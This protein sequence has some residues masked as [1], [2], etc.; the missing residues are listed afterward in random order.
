[1]AARRVG[2]VYNAFVPSP[3]DTGEQAS[4][5]AVQ[6][7]AE[8]LRDALQ[9]HGVLA[10]MIPLRRSVPGF[11][12]RLREERSDIIV[13][14]C[15]GYLGRPQWESNVAGVLELLQIPFTGSAAKALALCQDKFTTKAILEYAGLPTAPALLLRSADEPVDLE[16]PLIVKPNHEDASIGIHPDSVVHDAESLTRKVRRVLDDYSQPALVE[17]YL[18]GREFS[19]A[20][21]EDPVPRALPVSEIEFTSM[22]ADAPRICGYTAKWFENH[23][24]YQQTPPRCPAEVGDDLR[25][26]LQNIAVGAF[27]ALGCRDYARID[28]RTDIAGDVHILE[29]NPNP[30]VSRDAGFARALSAAGIAYPAFWLTT[31]DHAYRRGANR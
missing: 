28:L 3:A 4:E 6:P 2:I 24:L 12:R 20:V 15:E 27:Q 8:G 13:N 14:L 29:V 22:P 30:D 1:M 25:Q 9:A 31:I 5:E 11:L 18:D 17:T 26:R 16:F 21:I 10:S 23:P 19:V 7:M